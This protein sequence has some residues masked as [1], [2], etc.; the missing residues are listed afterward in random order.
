MSG[1]GH[2]SLIYPLQQVWRELDHKL[3]APRYSHVAFLVPDNILVD[4]CPV[5]DDQELDDQELIGEFQLVDD[6]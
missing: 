6:N 5:K 4:P 3:S 2:E 1:N